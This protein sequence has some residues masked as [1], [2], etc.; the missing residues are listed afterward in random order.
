MR[1]ARL[2]APRTIELTETEQPT[3]EQGEA[4]VKVQRVS[5]CG[6]DTYLMYDQDLPEEMYPMTHG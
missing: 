1:S 2:I 5:A 6:S 4:L 3:P